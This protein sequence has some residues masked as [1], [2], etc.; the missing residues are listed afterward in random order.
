[1]ELKKKR[2]EL[3]KEVDLLRENM[4][5]ISENAKRESEIIRSLD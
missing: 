1:M 3:E 5:D 2:K 4:R